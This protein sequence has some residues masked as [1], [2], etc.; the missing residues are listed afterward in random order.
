MT[1]EKKNFTAKK[2]FRAFCKMLWTTFFVSQKKKK[3]KKKKACCQPQNN[4]MIFNV[5]GVRLVLHVY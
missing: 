1:E 3:K 4:S 2:V 5:Y